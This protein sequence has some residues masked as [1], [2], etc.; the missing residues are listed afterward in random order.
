MSLIEKDSVLT[1]DEVIDI[2][3]ISKPTIL[4]YIHEGRLRAIKVGKGWRILHSELF[5]FLNGK[6]EFEDA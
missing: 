5:R 2:L 6:P 4:K 1:T 3:R